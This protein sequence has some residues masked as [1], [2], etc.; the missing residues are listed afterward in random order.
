MSHLNPLVY[1]EESAEIQAAELSPMGTSIANQEQS[2]SG[3]L[4]G[5]GYFQVRVF[6]AAD[7]EACWRFGVRAKHDDPPPVNL[8]LWLDNEQIG[9][10]SFTN[11]DKTWETL[12]LT[13]HAKPGAYWFRVWFVN[14]FRDPEL[15]VDRNA[16]IENIQIAH[17]EE[18]L[19][20]GS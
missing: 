12:S 5:E 8:A 15:N 2:N 4:F 19:C 1:V 18:N 16:Y 10:L 11:G 7:S 17:V 20:E 3:T 13:T 9:E 6:L 14:D